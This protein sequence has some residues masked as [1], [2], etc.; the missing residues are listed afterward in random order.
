MRVAL[1]IA[2]PIA[3][4]VGQT[5]TAGVR[6]GRTG[7]VGILPTLPPPDKHVGANASPAQVVLPE[8]VGTNAACRPACNFCSFTQFE[9]LVRD[10]VA[11][12]PDLRELW[13][14]QA[15]TGRDV[16]LGGGKLRGLLHWITVQLQ[17]HAPEAV[18]RMPSPSL[19]ALSLSPGVDTDLF[20]SADVGGE[21]AKALPKYDKLD[22]LAEE[23]QKQ[24]VRCGGLT[25]DKISV[26]PERVDDPCGALRDFY[27]GRLHFHAIDAVEFREASRPDKDGKLGGITRASQVFRLLRCACD[28]PETQI[29]R[30]TLAMLPQ[31]AAQ[32]AERTI[33]RSEEVMTVAAM[34]KLYASSGQDLPRFLGRIRDAGFLDFV[35][36]KRIPLPGRDLREIL[37]IADDPSLFAAVVESGTRLIDVRSGVT[38][39]LQCL[40]DRGHTVCALA[41]LGS[42]ANH[43][44]AE[45]L[46]ALL[47][48][49]RT[50]PDYVAVIAAQKEYLGSAYLQADLAKAVIPHV[51]YL[52]AKLAPDADQGKMIDAMVNFP[53]VSGARGLMQA[54]S[55][56]EFL[57]AA[58]AL[59]GQCR[60]A[61]P[62]SAYLKRSVCDALILA[63]VDLFKRT[64]PERSHVDALRSLLTARQTYVDEAYVRA[65][66]TQLSQALSSRS[67]RAR[68]GRLT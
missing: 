49:A 45:C 6:P 34:Q 38:E 18:R 65:I 58:K 13:A 7:P 4:D 24:A 36:Q 8:R 29:P 12:I 67:R 55:S 22:A 63:N 37:P 46:A 17:T 42:L 27:D 51:R 39:A 44:A 19:A 14:W 35:L 61:D 30:E 33:G 59:A 26:S 66:Q 16:R 5:D 1:P 50:A 64:R 40:L 68:L 60:D 43:H 54:K 41:R 25:L 32:D 2:R 21:L 15:S 52:I 62:T 57:E 48:A 31:L 23:F 3:A 9:T 56:S 10:K 28:L 53:L 11:G 47:P 20:A